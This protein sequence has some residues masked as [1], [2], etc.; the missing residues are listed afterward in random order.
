MHV[1]VC[2]NVCI[3]GGPF[4]LDGTPLIVI[5]LCAKVSPASSRPLMLTAPWPIRDFMCA[6]SPWQHITW[7]GYSGYE[8]VIKYTN[9]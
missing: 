5:P 8:P 1:Y 9:V 4:K 7:A 6:R 2:R 3:V